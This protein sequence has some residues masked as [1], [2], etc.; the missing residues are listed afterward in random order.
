MK[1]E[2]L[3]SFYG[4]TA[5]VTIKKDGTARL[6][7]KTAQGVKFVDKVYKTVAGAKRAWKRMN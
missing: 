7:G 5:S 3:T 4:A 1:K 2:F 6:I